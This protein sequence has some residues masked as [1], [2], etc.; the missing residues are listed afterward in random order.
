MKCLYCVDSNKHPEPTLA[1]LRTTLGAVVK[2]FDKILIDA[3]DEC[4]S[5][6]ELLDWMKS[7]HRPERII[8]E[9]MS[10][11]SHVRISLGSELLDSDI[12]TYV[13]ECVET[14]DNLKL[15]MT[16][17]MKKRLRVRGDGMF[18]LVAIWIDELKY[19]R[20]LKDITDKLEHLPTSLNAM[21]AS[22]VS[23]IMV[24]DLR[25][26][27][28][29]IP[30]LLFS[31]EQLTL[32]KIAAVACFSFSNGRPAFD[33]DRRFGNPKAVLDVC[34]GL[35]VMTED[36]VMLA[37]L[38]VK[39]FL[40]EQ[41]SALHVNEPD[42]YSFIARSCL[43]YLLDQFQ[44]CVAAGVGGFPLHDYAVRKWMSHALSSRGIE[45]TQS[46]IYEL[47]LEMLHPGREPYQ[48]W[49]STMDAISSFYKDYYPTPLFVCARWGFQHL[50]ARLLVLGVHSATQ[51]GS[52]C[53]ALHLAFE[54]GH[55]EVVK[56]LLDN[57]NMTMN[58]AVGMSHEQEFFHSP[59]LGVCWGSHQHC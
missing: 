25:Y 34:G 21:Y 2:G 27:Q 11:S 49:L 18:R 5:Q 39:E 47:A 14:S 36:G 19:C 43:T 50:T 42:T 23:K 26:A 51:S 55:L 20:S 16:E 31:V 48:L 9:R 17:V 12:K 29:I 7:L 33:T 52:G 59:S 53:T 54:H 35:V 3:L 38:T 56:R 8:E 37:H 22:M 13:D 10:N 41:E 44:P 6:A 30:W 58:P 24:D 32:E 15:L 45:D 28:T 57:P 4:A 1:Q 40:L 46:V